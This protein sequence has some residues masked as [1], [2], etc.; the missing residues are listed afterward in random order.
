MGQHTSRFGSNG[1]AHVGGA[2]PLFFIKTKP[3]VRRFRGM[4]MLLTISAVVL[5]LLGITMLG[6]GIQAGI[7]A[8]PV[9][10][11]GFLLIAGVF[12]RMRKEYS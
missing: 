7:L 12:F 1:L 9:T 6:I 3:V 4:K 8:P 5:V 2:N 10:G 11:V